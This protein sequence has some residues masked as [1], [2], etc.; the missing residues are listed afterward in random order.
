VNKAEVVA[1]HYWSQEMVRVRWRNG[2]VVAHEILPHAEP[3]GWWIAP[4][5]VDL[6]VNGFAGVDFQ[7]EELTGAELLRAVRDLQ[8][9]GCTRFLLTL[10]TDRWDRLLGKL[11]RLRTLRAESTVLRDAIAGWHI[12]GPFLLAEAGFRG[13]HDPA[14]M[15]DPTPDKVQALRA[16]AA[17]D[18][19]MLTLAPE[20]NGALEA[21]RLATA[22]GMKVSLGHTNASAQT[23]AAAVTA[24]AT[25]YTHLGNGCPPLLDR[26]D[27][28][29]W[30]VFETAGLALTIIPD[31]LHVSPPLF[32]LFHRVL[33]LPSIL[34][35]SD[36]MAAAGVKP[37]R[38]RLGNLQ[39]EVGADGAVLLP[40]TS[41]F[42]GSAL[43][44]VDGVFR[45]AAMLGVAWQQAWPRFGRG[46]A[47]W[48][49][50]PYGLREGACADFC[51]VRVGS[52]NSYTQ[53]RVIVAGE[54]LPFTA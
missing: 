7:T 6:Q 16:V 41:Q 37:G 24:G 53:L 21:I 52:N 12:E 26:R 4:G 17:D 23:L 19:V 38:Y 48:L 15:I 49:G 27:N 3:N 40:G 8:A 22:L 10:V 33:P 13:A 42:A 2:I 36:A 30:R 32:R 5:L 20:R 39:I 34:Y 50:L 11:A 45:A 31:A 14:C 28:I 44:P 18:L 9:A 51:L 1:Q 25:A 35:I 47:D 43:R 46:P 54:E 29:L